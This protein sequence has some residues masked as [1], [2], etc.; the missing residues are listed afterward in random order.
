MHSAVKRKFWNVE[1]ASPFWSIIVHS[2]HILLVVF[3]CTK[4]RRWMTTP[5]IVLGRVQDILRVSVVW[6][7]LGFV[8]TN[9]L[10]SRRKLVT[11]HHVFIND[12]WWLLVFVD[13]WAGSSLMFWTPAN[14][15][16]FPLCTR[17]RK[18]FQVIGLSNK[19]KHRRSFLAH[20]LPSGLMPG[21][22]ASLLICI[23]SCLQRTQN[24]HR[25][26]VFL[27]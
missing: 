2:R 26:R 18:A 21:H 19:T 23:W 12:Q 4:K 27:T 1:C 9:L 6:A 15:T 3:G 11:G 17:F 16:S 14:R 25:T 24:R 13:F 22:L 20:N 8:M 5:G 7:I 10:Q